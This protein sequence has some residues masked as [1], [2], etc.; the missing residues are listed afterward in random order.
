MNVI[1]KSDFNT[2]L[3]VFL[4]LLLGVPLGAPAQATGM[5]TFSSARPAIFQR[6]TLGTATTAAPV[7]LGYASTF[8]IL[9]KSGITDVPTSGVTGNVGTSPITGAADHLTCSEVNGMI[10]SVNAAGPAPC[11]VV[12]PGLLTKAVLS[13]QAAYT[14]AAGRAAGVTNLKGGN[15]GGLTLTPAVYKWSTGVVIPLS[16]HLS[17]A[18]NS[19]WIFQ[20]AQNLSVSSGV[21]I[22]LSGGAQAKNVF[23][24][25]AGQATLGT[26]SQFQGII[27]SKTLIAMQTGAS[28]NGRLFAQTAVTLQ[29]NSVS[30]H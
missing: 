23:W 25:V 12:N 16:L 18:S 22:I 11:N 8:V 17:G 6:A 2:A 7:N 21:S 19:V 14:D 24:Q 27:L 3:L 26:T 13:M 10:L 5:S 30:I 28:I 15:I 29:M 20:I 1:T 4:T 9:S